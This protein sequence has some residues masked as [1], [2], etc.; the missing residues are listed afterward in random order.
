MVEYIK[1][2][3]L[4]AWPIVTLALALVFRR[5]IQLLL[6][7]LATKGFKATWGSASMIVPS[8]E[9][10]KVEAGIRAANVRAEVKV[11]IGP[12]ELQTKILHEFKARGDY[13]TLNVSKTLIEDFRHLKSI[14]F[15]KWETEEDRGD[16][17]SLANFGLTEE[18]RKK[19]CLI[20]FGGGLAIQHCVS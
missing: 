13:D 1:A 17:V 15:L 11:P 5:E 18:G 4:W 19:V 14:G 10:T 7:N 3:A 20:V 9:D 16:Q 8:V 12:T 6:N 2:L